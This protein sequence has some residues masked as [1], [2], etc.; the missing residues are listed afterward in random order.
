MSK[1]TGMVFL[2][3]TA[4][5]A[6]GMIPEGAVPG[7]DGLLHCPLCGGAVE[8][9]FSFAGKERKVPCLC[10]CGARR[11]EEERLKEEAEQEAIRIERLRAEGIQD[12]G[13]RQWTFESAEDTAA[14]KA[15]RS[16]VRQWPEMRRRN[17]GLLF[18]GPV[19]TGKSYAAA[20][21]ANE[22]IAGGT[23]VLMTNFSKILNQ[24]GNMYTEERYRYIRSFSNY[25]LLIIDDLGIERSTEYAKEQVYA[26]VDERYKSGLPIIVT[27][28][29]TI[30][31]IRE[32]RLLAD[33]RITSRILEMCVPVNVNGPD[34]R[35]AKA[36][37]KQELMRELLRKE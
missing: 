1:D 11:R 20:C 18:W 5:T 3:E 24:M 34:R 25:P 19:G 13:I 37:G 30:G 27:T 15:A 29:L 26:V 32:P 28:N 9:R 22:L 33:A 4:R 17:V 12:R 16:Y 31:E 6:A 21:I 10:A 35:R 36:D 2:E 14:V 7:E 8:Y 23:P